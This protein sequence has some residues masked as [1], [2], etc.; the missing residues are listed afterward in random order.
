MP[1]KPKLFTW[2]EDKNQWL[3]TERAISFEEA[4]QYIAD[5]HVLD[6]VE[7]PNRERYRG[8]RIF[9]VEIRDY[10]WLVPFA[11]TDDEVFLKT[12]IPSRKATRKYR[13]GTHG[14]P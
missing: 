10:V 3:K 5:G 11:E 12:V 2:N 14:N 8:Q 1:V 9:V 4:V 13:G 7:H 6:I